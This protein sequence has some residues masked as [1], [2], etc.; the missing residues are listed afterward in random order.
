MIR[1]NEKWVVEVDENGNYMPRI[2]KHKT[3]IV[4]YK[5]GR[6]EERPAYGPPAGYYTSLEHALNGIVEKDFITAVMSKDLT[7]MEAIKILGSIS[8]S[9][10]TAK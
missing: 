5:D 6:Q 2:D 9:V 8:K 7:L 1:V 10:T 3:E 4:T